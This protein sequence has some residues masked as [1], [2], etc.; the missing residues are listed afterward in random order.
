MFS[1]LEIMEPVVEKYGFT[2]VEVALRWIVHHAALKGSYGSD[3]TVVGFS[4][5]G[6][7]QP[8]LADIEKGPLPFGVVH[9]LDQAWYVTKADAANFRHGELKYEYD[10]LQS[11]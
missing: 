7:L 1:A 2:L 8:N 11:S 3:T 10:T 5:F 9:C 6:Q 4:S